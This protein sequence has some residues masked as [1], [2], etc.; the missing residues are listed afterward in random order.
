MYAC[1]DVYVPHEI[2]SGSFYTCSKKQLNDRWE[3]YNGTF[4]WLEGPEE[5]GYYTMDDEEFWDAV[6]KENNASRRKQCR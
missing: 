3:E 1:E 2:I 5:I 6:E 4:I